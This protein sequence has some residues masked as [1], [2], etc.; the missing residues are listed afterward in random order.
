MLLTGGTGPDITVC[1][2]AWTYSRVH[3]SDDIHTK[4][5]GSPLH[6]K[7]GTSYVRN[8]EMTMSS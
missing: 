1:D 8:L 7:D 3:Y 5:D 2:V 4:I 6:C